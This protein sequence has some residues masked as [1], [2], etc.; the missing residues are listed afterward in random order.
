MKQ[1]TEL[2]FQ[3]EFTFFLKKT[4]IHSPAPVMVAHTREVC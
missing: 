2:I 4:G 1:K 3:I